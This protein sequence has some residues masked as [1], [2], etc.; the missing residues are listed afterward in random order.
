MGVDPA[1]RSR[2]RQRRRQCD[3]AIR[4]RQSSRA[5]APGG[6]ARHDHRRATRGRRPMA[7]AGRG[8]ARGGQALRAGLGKAASRGAAR[9]A[10]QRGGQRDLQPL[11]RARKD[12]SSEVIGADRD[13][14]PR[15]VFD[16]ALNARGCTTSFGCTTGA[17]GIAPGTFLPTGSP[18]PVDQVRVGPAVKLRRLGLLASRATAR[19][20]FAGSGPGPNAGPVPTSYAVREVRTAK[21]SSPSPT[22]CGA[23]P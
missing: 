19:W 17:V 10:W 2:L 20:W 13:D 1:R 23:S 22:T 16:R 18:A 4:D 6:R 15:V 5:R 14:R 7:G 8:Q 21:S 9:D 3:L 11:E 12:H